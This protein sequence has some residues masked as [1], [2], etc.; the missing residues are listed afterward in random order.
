MDILENEYKNRTRKID[1]RKIWIKLS[2]VII[3]YTGIWCKGQIQS[4]QDLNKR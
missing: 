3:Q 1:D 2:I 4:I